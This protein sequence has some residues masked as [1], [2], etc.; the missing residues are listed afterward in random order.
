MHFE[1]Y[2]YYFDF[3]KNDLKE[4]LIKFIELKQENQKLKFVLIVDAGFI[5]NDEE[6][7]QI[8]SF[9]NKI[10]SS[11]ILPNDLI[12]SVEANGYRYKNEEWVKII[13]L[14][15]LL[16]S[17]NIEFGFED[18][19]RTWSV[20]E[21]DNAN[22]V[23]VG[24]ADYI[25]QRKLSP[26][27]ALLD[28]Y[29]TVTT[30]DYKH[31]ENQDHTSESR[32]VFGVLNSD[33]IVCAGYSQFLKALIDEV[34]EDNLKIYINHVETSEDDKTLKGW[35]ANV[36]VYVN[37]EKYGINGYYYLDP[38]WDCGTK[39]K[40]SINYFM[41]PLGDIENFKR[42]FIRNAKYLIKEDEEE[43]KKPS[44]KKNDNIFNARS[45]PRISFTKDGFEYS[46][47]FIYDYLNLFPEEA[48]KFSDMFS[49][50]KLDMAE[51]RYITIEEQLKLLGTIKQSLDLNKVVDNRVAIQIYAHLQRMIEKQ[52]ISELD[53]FKNAIDKLQ[54]QENGSKISEIIEKI[55]SFL[56]KKQNKALEDIEENEGVMDLQQLAYHLFSMSNVNRDID[57]VLLKS[58]KPVEIGCLM[59]ALKKCYKSRIP[60][61]NDLE[62]NKI[63][64][65]I[66]LRAAQTRKEVFDRFNSSELNEYL[67]SSSFNND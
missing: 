16:K 35:H 15:D 36:I 4:A 55:E 67:E 25:R 60:N 13:K 3:D 54:N 63:I 19:R 14:A 64:H 18:Q 38:T 44:V 45:Y 6:I 7:K 51:I 57:K 43:T 9:V 28:A 5:K 56:V 37:D 20:E 58:S 32:S 48:K 29:L 23:I 42:P 53:N 62:V 50:E 46:W 2:Y 59:M 26:F 27:E 11:G 66:I 8:V 24:T 1:K 17:K 47:R 12:V 30:R 61:I 21:V 41:I 52:N 39:K 33:K 40:K 10:V 31:E 34:G 65:D 22:S 49:N